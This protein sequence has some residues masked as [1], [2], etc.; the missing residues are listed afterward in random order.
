[1]YFEKEADLKISK[2]SKKGTSYF[3]SVKNNGNG[4][5][6]GSYLGVYVKGKVVKKVL[7][8]SLK[9]GQS[10]NIKVA[11]S[12]KYTKSTKTFKADYTNKVKEVY[13]NNNSKKAK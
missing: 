13:K 9:P 5:A 8:Q 3:V 6:K 11:L 4:N 10:K 1:M 12:S 2:V 7:V